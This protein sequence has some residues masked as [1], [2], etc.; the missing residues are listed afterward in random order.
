MTVSSNLLP[1]GSEETKTN[2]IQT[3][4]LTILVT[5]EKSSGPEH[6][7]CK[8]KMQ[9]HQMPHTTASEYLKIYLSFLL[10]T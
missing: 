9:G 1:L 2:A 10:L 3:P 7:S 6:L 8:A 5:L 4:S